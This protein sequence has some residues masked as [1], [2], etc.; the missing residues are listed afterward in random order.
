MV[1]EITD[2]TFGTEVLA[3]DLPVVLD[4]WADWCEPC[5]KLDQTVQQLAGRYGGK[6]K[7]CRL[8]VARNPRTV[9][10]YHVMTLPTLL[11]I[12]GGHVVGQ[13]VGAVQRLSDLAAKIEGHLGLSL[14]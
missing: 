10:Q 9:A 8:D 6:V 5:R 11:F 12:R 7:I 13:H 3:S 2:E 4:L 14:A 1:R